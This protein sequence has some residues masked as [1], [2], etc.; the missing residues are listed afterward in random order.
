MIRKL[1]ISI[2]FLTLSLTSG[3][4]IQINAQ[5][6]SNIYLIGDHILLWVDVKHDNLAD[7]RIE[8]IYDTLRNFEVLRRDVRDLR[9]DGRHVQRHEFVLTT[10][11][12]GAYVIPAI[13]FFVKAKGKAQTDTLASRAIPILV[14]NILVDMDA[15]IKA[16]KPPLEAPFSLWDWWELIL[17]AYLLLLVISLLV[18]WLEQ[19]GKK[20]EEVIPIRSRTPFEIAMSRLQELEAKKLWQEGM[21][22]DYYIAL[23]EIIRSYLEQRFGIMAMESTTHEILVDLKVVMMEEQHKTEL[24]LLLELSDYVKFAKAKPL[25]NEHEE[26][27]KRAYVFVR[28]TKPIVRSVE[29]EVTGV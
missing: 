16:I 19:R 24:K 25:T 15:E 4:Q 8:T 12:S 14:T 3:G 27:L 11:D 18:Y 22:K 6:D 5:V 9:E 23:T 13:R 29:K 1:F 2:V 7:I 28:A 21:I 26:S 10:F 17:G 20:G